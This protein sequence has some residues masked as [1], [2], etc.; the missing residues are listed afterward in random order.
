[1]QTGRQGTA[2]MSV[3]LNAVLSKKEVRN[4][5]MTKS[6]NVKKKKSGCKTILNNEIICGGLAM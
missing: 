6:K 3:F 1:M 4:Q 5:T 2:N